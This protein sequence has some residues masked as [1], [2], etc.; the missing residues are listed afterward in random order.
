MNPLLSLCMA[1]CLRPDTLPQSL[2]GLLSQTYEPLEIIVLA[3]GAHPEAIR[4][5]EACRD[6]RLRWFATDRPSGMVPAWNKVCSEARGKYLLFCAD[7][8]VLQPHAVEEQVRLLEN[9]PSVLFCHADWIF[10]DDDGLP[11]GT[12]ISPRGRYIESGAAA[13]SRFVVVTGACMQT[14]V[15]RRDAWQEVGGWDED[16]GNPGDNSLYLKLLRRGDVG[17]VPTVA[18]KYRLRTRKPDSWEKRFRNLREDYA[19]GT[20]HLASPPPEAALA[21][22]KI[23]RRFLNRLARNGLSLRETAPTGADAKALDVWLRDH[24]WNETL[25]A[26]LCAWAHKV[27]ASGRLD[28]LIASKESIRAAGKDLLV[29]SLRRLRQR[30]RM[31]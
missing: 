31:A 17:H 15:I 27:G 26:R 11:V 29:V 1:T 24:V 3:D 13:W 9:N 28:S 14:T 21:S 4:L 6:P 12:A 5:L 19:L 30:E 20:R 10:I 23:R 16:A 8:D 22:K 2:A 18:V 25:F 7:D